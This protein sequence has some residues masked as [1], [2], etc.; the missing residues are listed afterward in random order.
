MQMFRRR[1][2]KASLLL[3]PFLI[4]ACATPVDLAV[5][6]RPP[7]VFVHGNGDTAGLW[8]TTQWSSN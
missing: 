4:A 2:L 6:P 7:I 8:L 1:L 3:M 5:N